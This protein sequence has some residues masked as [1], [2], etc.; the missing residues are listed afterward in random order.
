MFTKLMIILFQ[1]YNLII[2]IVWL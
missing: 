1:F 2:Y